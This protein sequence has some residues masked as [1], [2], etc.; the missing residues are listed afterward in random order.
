MT[1]VQSGR[2]LV[3]LIEDD[4][5]SREMY[6]LALDMFG[7][8]TVV[9]GTAAEAMRACTHDRPDL[10]VTDLTLPDMDG[11][12]LC[13]ALGRQPETAGVPVIALT[14]RSAERDIE[15][16]MA[17]GARR[18]LVKPCAPDALADAIREVLATGS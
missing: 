8:R 17:A 11:I 13:T 1:D 18:V 2:S 4:R 3:L 16:A 7:L 6:A 15:Q 12:T 14:G 9:A 10:I 5:D